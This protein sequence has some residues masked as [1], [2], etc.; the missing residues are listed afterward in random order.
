MNKNLIA[1]VFTLVLFTTPTL[2]RAE[3]EI[4]EVLITATRIETPSKEVGSSTTIVTA[5]EIEAS[6]SRT[7]LEALKAPA[8]IEEMYNPE[9]FARSSSQIC[10]I[11]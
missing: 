9:I 2:A 11:R 3:S 6:Q 7:V 5:E 1:T 4:E 8:T 10:E